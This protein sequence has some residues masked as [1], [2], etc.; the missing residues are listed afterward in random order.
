MNTE[1]RNEPNMPPC[2]HCHAPF[3]DHIEGR[4]PYT[5]TQYQRGNSGNAQILVAFGVIVGVLLILFMVWFAYHT[6]WVDTHCTTVLG[7][8]VCQ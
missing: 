5:R 1:V 3:A 8:Q 2:S 4:C 7:T 6:W